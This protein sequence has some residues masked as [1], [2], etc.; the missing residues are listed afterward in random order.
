M[1]VTILLL[2]IA[3]FT[4]C[5]NQ[6]VTEKSDVKLTKLEAFCDSFTHKFPSWKQNDILNERA[7]K[8]LKD[9]VPSLI[10]AGILSDFPLKLKSIRKFSSDKYAAHLS[11]DYTLQLKYDVTFDVIAILTENETMNLKTDSL[12]SVKGSFKKYVEGD[13]SE[14]TNRMVN[15]P[16]VQIKKD[17]VYLDSAAFDFGVIVIGNSKIESYNGTNRTR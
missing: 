9:T 11:T 10:S 5:E 4:S 8:N 1:K 3:L 14:Y 16:L 15:T 13:Y 6:V 17:D 12:Y 2:F 7:N